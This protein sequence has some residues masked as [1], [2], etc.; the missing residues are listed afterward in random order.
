[1]SALTMFA[2]T[3]LVVLPLGAA[4]WLEGPVAG[5]PTLVDHPIAG[6]G[7]T[8]RPLFL[9]GSWKATNSLDPTNPVAATVPVSKHTAFPHPAV[10]GTAPR[11]Y[12]LSKPRG[13]SIEHRE[14]RINV[15]SVMISPFPPL[16]FSPREISSPTSK[17]QAGSAIRTGT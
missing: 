6:P 1:M 11:P 9:D 17:M 4:G 3:L 15:M 2:T 7:L 13:P 5:E 14:T 12:S 10:A 8:G 16:L